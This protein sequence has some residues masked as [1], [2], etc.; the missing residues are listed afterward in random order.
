MLFNLAFQMNC[1]YTILNHVL[2]QLPYL[3]NKCLLKAVNCPTDYNIIKQNGCPL[4]FCFPP[5]K[6]HDYATMAQSLSQYQ[7]GFP[8]VRPYPVGSTNF[9]AFFVHPLDSLTAV[10]CL[11]IYALNVSPHIMSLSKTSLNQRT[12]AH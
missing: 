2:C 1:K 5:N 6:S 11:L 7:S 8:S 9:P 12:Q 4:Y 3:I 10:R